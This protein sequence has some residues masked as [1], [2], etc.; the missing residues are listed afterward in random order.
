MSGKQPPLSGSWASAGPVADPAGQ[1]DRMNLPPGPW[2]PGHPVIRAPAAS[3]QRTRSGHGGNRPNKRGRSQHRPRWYR[4]GR[5]LAMRQPPVS[6]P[7]GRRWWLCMHRHSLV[8]PGHQVVH[9][10]LDNTLRPAGAA[11]APC[12]GQ[13]R[14]MTLRQPTR[15]AAASLTAVSGQ[16]RLAGLLPKRDPHWLTG[17]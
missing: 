15:L 9:L 5:V 6:R 8:L 1:H 17:R 13:S 10:A 3:R 12:S 11:V 4:R 14:T 2:R 7:D 16:Q